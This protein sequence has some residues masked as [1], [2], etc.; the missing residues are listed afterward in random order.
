ML[1][2]DNSRQRCKSGACRAQRAADA[3]KKSASSSQQSRSKSPVVRFLSFT[4]LLRQHAHQALSPL[5]GGGAGD[6]SDGLD[7]SSSDR[8]PHAE[9][10]PELQSS[11]AHPEDAR[12]A[13]SHPAN[14]HALTQQILPSC[15]RWRWLTGQRARCRGGRRRCRWPAAERLPSVH[16]GRHHHLCHRPGAAPSSYARA[17]AAHCLL[18]LHP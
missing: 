8:M 18:V 9:S 12:M 1:R 4:P 11:S 16:Q 5:A 10:A 6:Q 13:C 15:C 7:S 3:D 14:A 17:L 2:R